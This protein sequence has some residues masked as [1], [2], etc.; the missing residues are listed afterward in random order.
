LES[1]VQDSDCKVLS[2]Q[3]NWGTTR[4]A[5]RHNIDGKSMRKRRPP[6]LF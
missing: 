6:I 2:S 1:S 5:L 4:P 3:K